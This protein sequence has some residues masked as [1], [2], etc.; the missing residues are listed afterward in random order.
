MSESR[1]GDDNRVLIANCG[2]CDKILLRE[3]LEPKTAQGG[4]VGNMV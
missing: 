3:F 4:S 2:L 1:G